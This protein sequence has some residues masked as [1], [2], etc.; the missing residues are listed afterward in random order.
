VLEGVLVVGIKVNVFPVAL[1][2]ATIINGNTSQSGAKE[3]QLAKEH[4]IYVNI[5][6]LGR[7]K[8]NWVESLNGNCPLLISMAVLPELDPKPRR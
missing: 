8:A 2:R 7:E 4:D 3:R 6:V 5:H 1:L